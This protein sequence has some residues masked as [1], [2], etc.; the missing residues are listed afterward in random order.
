[1]ASYN[2]QKIGKLVMKV[3]DLHKT[4]DQFELIDLSIRIAGELVL[5]LETAKSII[6]LKRVLVSFWPIKI[7]MSY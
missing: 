2:V 7:L 3:T 1:M 4:N 6:Y 5:G